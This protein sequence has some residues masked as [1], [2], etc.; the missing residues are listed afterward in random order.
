MTTDSHF[1]QQ[2]QRMVTEQIMRRGVCDPRV[3]E[4]MRQVPRHRF[5]PSEYA[6][7]A[8]SDGPLPIGQGQ[9]IA[10]PYIVALMTE[11]LDLQGDETVLEIDTG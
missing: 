3:L 4:A 5:T 9:T 7:M 8:Y 6:D 10:P 2:R 11:L 1:L